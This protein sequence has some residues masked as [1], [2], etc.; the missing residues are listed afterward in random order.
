MERPLGRRE[1]PDFDHVDMS[2]LVMPGTVDY[3]NRSLTPPGYRELYDQAGEPS[4][5]GWSVSWMCSVMNRKPYDGSWLYHR[6]REVDGMPPGEGTT[7][8]AAARVVSTEGHRRIRLK[9]GET[10]VLK[11]WHGIKR[12]RWATSVDQIRTFLAGGRPVVLGIPWYREFDQPGG[13][14]HKQ[15]KARWIGRDGNLSEVRGGHAVMVYGALDTVNG[16]KLLTAWPDFPVTVMP[17]EVLE[18]LLG[19]NGEAMCPTDK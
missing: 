3:V 19:E 11:L 14:V 12:P 8:R 6:A 1:P 16:V 9:T 10:Q 2:P 18:R 15:G 13:F 7:L 5:C 17:Y 4:A